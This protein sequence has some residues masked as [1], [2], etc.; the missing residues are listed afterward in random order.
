MAVF[1]IDFNTLPIALRFRM[2]RNFEFLH[3]IKGLRLA[4]NSVNTPVECSSSVLPHALFFLFGCVIFECV[5][6]VYTGFPQKR[7]PFLKI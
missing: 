5:S 1:S 6:V 7:R 4:W 3:K 2:G